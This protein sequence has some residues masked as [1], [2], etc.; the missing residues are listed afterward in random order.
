MK[1]IFLYLISPYPK[2]CFFYYFAAIKKK[3]VL[4]YFHSLRDILGWASVHSIPNHNHTKDHNLQ[5]A[6]VLVILIIIFRLRAGLDGS[7]LSHTIPGL[8][9]KYEAHD[10]HQK[11]NYQSHIHYQQDAKWVK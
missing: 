6:A 9:F 3:M 5:S 1:T 10:V 11:L 2:I 8:N 7:L 4:E